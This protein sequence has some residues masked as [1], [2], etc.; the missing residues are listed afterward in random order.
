MWFGKVTRME[1]NRLPAVAPY[2]QVEGTRSRGRK[3]KKW[4]GNGNEDL[5]AQGIKMREAV[6]TNSNRRIL[7]SLDLR[8][9]R[10]ER[11]TEE[12]LDYC[13]QFSVFQ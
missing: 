1:E 5:R 2:V 4:M 7:R 8:P 6:D 3:P 11:L 13:T 9:H 10:R 12:K